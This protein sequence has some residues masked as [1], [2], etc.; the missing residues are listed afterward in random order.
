MTKKLRKT[1]KLGEVGFQKLGKNLV[2]KSGKNCSKSRN[3]DTLQFCGTFKFLSLFQKGAKHTFLKPKLA[4]LAFWVFMLIKR[5]GGNGVN[6]F[7][8]LAHHSVVLSPIDQSWITFMHCLSSPAS[9]SSIKKR[10]S[11]LT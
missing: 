6:N 3:L 5:G 4:S 11:R 7:P 9:R 2:L 10:L 8:S 1:K